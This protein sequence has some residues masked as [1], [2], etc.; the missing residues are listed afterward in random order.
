MYLPA[1]PADPSALWGINFN[2][3]LK[4]EKFSIFSSRREFFQVSLVV[5]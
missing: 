4:Y 5:L 3:K 2:E 1:Y